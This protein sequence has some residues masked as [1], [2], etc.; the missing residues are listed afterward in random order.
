VIG[1]YLVEQILGK[2]SFAEVKLGKHIKT[3]DKV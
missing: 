2:G 1:N 3:G